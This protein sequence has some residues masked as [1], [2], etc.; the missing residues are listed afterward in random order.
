MNEK[1]LL[2]ALQKTRNYIRV[3]AIVMIIIDIVFWLFNGSIKTD[4]T[5]MVVLTW[6]I[7]SIFLDAYKEPRK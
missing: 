3:L 6:F 4:S 5:A 1:A 2:A 7:I